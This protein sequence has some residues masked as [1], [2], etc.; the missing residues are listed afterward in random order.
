MQIVVV[1]SPSCYVRSF[2]IWPHSASGS[3]HNGNQSNASGDRAQEQNKRLR[4]D[5]VGGAATV[6]LLLPHPR[7][8]TGEANDDGESKQSVRQ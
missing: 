4:L 6:P 5:H 8:T 7:N 3:L 2:L 1:G